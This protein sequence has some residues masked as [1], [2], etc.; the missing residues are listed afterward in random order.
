MTSPDGAIDAVL[1]ERNGGA[2]TSFGYEIHLVPIGGNPSANTETAFLYAAARSEQ[3]YGANLR[4]ASPESLT[5]EYLS[6]RSVVLKQSQISVAGRA[7]IVQ[8]VSGVSDPNAPPGG[9]LYNLQGRPHD[10]Q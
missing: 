6:A 10:Q 3:A 8:L 2:T 7:I 1:V 5:V 9:M 4:W